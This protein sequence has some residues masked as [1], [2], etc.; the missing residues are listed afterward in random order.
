MCLALAPIHP[1]M[2]TDFRVIPYHF[3]RRYKNLK[4][5]KEFMHGM[6]KSVAMLSAR[7][8]QE[9]NLTK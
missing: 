9:D 8:V 5:I 4:T 6:D 7:R 1:R 3:L 2:N